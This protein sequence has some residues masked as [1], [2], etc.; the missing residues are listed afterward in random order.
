MKK[1]LLLITLSLGLLSH[2]QNGVV[3]FEGNGK[4]FNIENEVHGAYFEKAKFKEL[5]ISSEVL[6]KSGV[7]HLEMY[8]EYH[9]EGKIEGDKLIVYYVYKTNRQS[10][11]DIRKQ[12]DSISP[13]LRP[14]NW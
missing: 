4:I 10:T 7:S 6:E 2:S 9:F 5:V 14:K 8:K 13:I 1:I 12:R 11:V 3:A